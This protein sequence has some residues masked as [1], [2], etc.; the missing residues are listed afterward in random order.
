MSSPLDPLRFPRVEPLTALRR[1]DRQRD[2]PDERRQREHSD[3]E[4]QDAEGDEGG[5]H[6]DVLA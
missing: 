2:K 6:V 5:P 4:E 1:L 3:E